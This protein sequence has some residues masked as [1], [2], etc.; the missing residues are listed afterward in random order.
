MVEFEYAYRLP[1]LANLRLH[2]RD[3]AKLKKAQKRA[4]ILAWGAFGL[5]KPK[6]PVKVTF[7]RVAPSKL[8]DDNLAIAFKYK[9]DQLA[10]LFGLKDDA[11]PEVQWCYAQTKN[12]TPR[13]YGVRITIEDV[14][15]AAIDQ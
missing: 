1:S 12:K 4:L 2:W 8:D 15:N 10:A 5:T 14:S 7:T 6:F 9:R 11:G 3:M 13:Y